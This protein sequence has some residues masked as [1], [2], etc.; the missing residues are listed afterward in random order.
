MQGRA[1]VQEY[2]RECKEVGFDVVEL[3]AR[4]APLPDSHLLRLIND[5][6]QV[7]WRR[8]EAFSYTPL[9]LRV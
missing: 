1:T 8:G 2:L 7:R 5:V 3:S 6:Q 4:F 9:D